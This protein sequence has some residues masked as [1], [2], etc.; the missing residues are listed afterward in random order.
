MG[1]SVNALKNVGKGQD[2]MSA[3]RNVEYPMSNIDP[4]DSGP[5]GAGIVIVWSGEAEPLNCWREIWS[6]SI[7]T[8]RKVVCEKTLYPDDMKIEREKWFQRLFMFFDIFEEVEYGF[9][10]FREVFIEIIRRH[11]LS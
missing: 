8:H 5:S 2:G 11:L 6:L 7:Y 9:T 1:F 3:G 4:E 10:K